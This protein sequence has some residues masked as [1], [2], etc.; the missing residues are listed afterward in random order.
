MLR[1]EHVTFRYPDHV[2]PVLE[3]F[4]VDI[5][6]G[7]RI[8]V[9]GKNGCGKTTFANLIL[10]KLQ[11]SEGRIHFPRERPVI[12]YLPQHFDID[13]EGTVLEI[14]QKAFP[15]LHS[16]RYRL[17]AL[18]QRFE[19]EPDNQT[20]QQEYGT[21]LDRFTRDGGWNIDNRC[22]RALAE[23]GLDE[24]F[25]LRRYKDL[26]GGEKTRVAIAGLL[27]KKPD[28]L[29][30][31]EPTNHLDLEMVEWLEEFV[32]K[33]HGTV[34]AISHDRAFIDQ[35]A[36]RLIVFEREGVMT[37]RGNYSVYKEDRENE[38]EHQLEKWSERR[39]KIRQLHDASLKRRQWAQKFQSETRP[40][41][42]GAV[43]ESIVNPAKTMMMQAKHIEERMKMLEERYP[44]EKPWIEKKHRIDFDLA[45]PPSN[46]IFGV[47]GV[48]HAFGDTKV[49]DDFNLHIYRGDHV[50]LKGPNGSGKTTLLRMLNRALEPDSG[51]ISRS[52]RL[53][54][55]YYDQEH[56]Q[57]DPHAT[58]IDFLMRHNSDTS[59]VRTVMGCL[60]IGEDV[61]HR[62]IGSLSVG[63]RGKV[64]L[65]VLLIT[66]CNV[67]LLDEPTN[68]LDLDTREQIEDA[69]SD[70]PGTILF[71][72]H[73]R[74]FI[75]KLAT[76][77]IELNQ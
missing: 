72:S 40:E 56:R 12:G 29:L 18:E 8:A 50:H 61:V 6:E 16:M 57:L 33:F 4:C 13:S 45:K 7:D 70:Y 15:E 30:L 25:L 2:E 35:I 53:K 42:G 62:P 21:L 65:G 5:V 24:S 36:Q 54:I 75:E 69:L 77:T 19:K 59:F 34:I 43:Y 20:T 68:H 64:A 28:I 10:G 41:G 76:G 31:D 58:V 32:K 39:K 74:R 63:E 27:V 73:D 14:C 48:S 9:I 71:V 47:I 23:T 1:F 26:S 17:K 22:A 51:D 46:V 38:Q 55:G 11:P 49:F 67:L 37:R 3:D 60:N 52:G 44:I 66:R